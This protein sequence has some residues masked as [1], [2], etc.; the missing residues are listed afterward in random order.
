MSTTLEHHQEKSRETDLLR[1]SKVEPPIT[2]GRYNDEEWTNLKREFL[3]LKESKMREEKVLTDEN[4]R[5]RSEV[6]ALELR[7]KQRKFTME[8]IR[9][10]EMRRQKNYST[11]EPRVEENVRYRNRNNSYKYNTRN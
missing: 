6:R 8:N 3:E 1:Q 11:V 5:L 10:L 7:L 2:H 4:D 9:S